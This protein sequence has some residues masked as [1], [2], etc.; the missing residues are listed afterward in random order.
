MK[1]QKV[2]QYTEI[3]KEDDSGNL[4]IE[5]PEALFNTLDWTEETDLE[6]IVED[7]KI[8]LKAKS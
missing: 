4:Y 6:W 3:V 1:Q 8:T 7:D 2:K 5:I